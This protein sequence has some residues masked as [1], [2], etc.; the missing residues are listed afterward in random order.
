[1]H[2]YN[3][4]YAQVIV[5][6]VTGLKSFIMMMIPLQEMIVLIRYPDVGYLSDPNKTCSQT[7]LYFYVLWHSDLIEMYKENFNCYI[8]KSC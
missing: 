8:F 1:M 4:F 5:G 6:L 2:K 3:P 7:G